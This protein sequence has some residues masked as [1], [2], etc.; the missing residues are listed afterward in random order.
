MVNNKINDRNMNSKFYPV[1]TLVLLVA[2]LTMG[3]YQFNKNQEASMSMQLK[4]ETPGM[5]SHLNK[6][7]IE[8]VVK[9]VIK[10]NPEL[11]IDSIRELNTRKAKEEYDRVAS[12]VKAKTKELEEDMDDPRAG[13]ANAKIKLVEFFDYNC[14]Y[15]KRMVEIKKKILD[16]NTDVQIVFK[17]LP[18]LGEA[19]HLVTKAALAVN[20]M[21]KSKYFQFHNELLNLNGPKT[22]EAIEALV[23][24]VGL[25]VVKFREALK[26]PKIEQIIAKNMR[27]AEEIGVNGTPA[28]VFAGEF[29]PGAVP[30]DEFKNRIDRT[31]TQ[32][33]QPAAAAAAPVVSETP[34]A[35]AVPAPAAAAVPAPAANTDTQVKVEAKPA[36]AVAPV[37]SNPEQK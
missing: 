20:L 18:I 26:D 33:A 36:E 21:D 5:P 17:E 7:E 24:K 2:L 16:E 6:E 12:L 11:I 23:T 9:E 34:A 3:Y 4:H 1:L 30:Y 10:K 14:G 8:L 37:P 13:N 27:L 22:N 32:Q 28:Y 25:D 15:C 35:A 31:R 29:L 19:S